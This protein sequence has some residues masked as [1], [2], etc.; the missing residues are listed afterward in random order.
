MSFCTCAVCFAVSSSFDFFTTSLVHRH[1]VSP[2]RSIAIIDA[3]IDARSHR[4]SYMHSLRPH[5]SLLISTREALSLARMLR[6]PLFHS[7]SRHTCRDRSLPFASRVQLTRAREVSH[8]SLHSDLRFSSPGA[9]APPIHQS[10]IAHF[11]H[12]SPSNDSVDLILCLLRNH[13]SA[14]SA[15]PECPHSLSS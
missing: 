7:Q 10:L 6:S 14:E 11:V 15:P 1:S 2:L 9:V 12:S 4:Y 8:I 3:P 13:E 5:L